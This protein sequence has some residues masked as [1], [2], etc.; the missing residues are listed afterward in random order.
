MLLSNGD[1]IVVG[2]YYPSSYAEYTETS[3]IVVLRLNS[4]GEAQWSVRI[5]TFG[6]DRA[7]SVA[8]QLLHPTDEEFV[9][10][11]GV[12]SSRGGDVILLS[13]NPYNGEFK[14]YTPS[15]FIR[16]WGGIGEV[17]WALSAALQVAHLRLRGRWLVG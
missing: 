7:T 3:D 5:D 16:I 1:Q 12:T 4:N 10:I 14:R 2:T 8:F 17:T 15:L 9:V 11:A 13:I 6:D